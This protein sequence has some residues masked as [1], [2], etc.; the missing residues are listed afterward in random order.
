[1]YPARAFAPCFLARFPA[2]T[3]FINSFVPVNEWVGMY[4]L[5]ASRMQSLH[6]SAP[7]ARLANRHKVEDVA[8]PGWPE[9]MM[10][11]VNTG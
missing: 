10:R 4:C 11:Q 1:L 8:L 3:I 9:K 5:M 2:K 7:L 6:F